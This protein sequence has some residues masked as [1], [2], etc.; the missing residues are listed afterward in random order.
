MLDMAPALYWHL[1]GDALIG[2]IHQRVLAHAKALAKR[3]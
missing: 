2:R 1:W 3:P